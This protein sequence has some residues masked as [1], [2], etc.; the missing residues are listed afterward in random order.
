MSKSNSAGAPKKRHGTRYIRLDT[1]K[2]EACWDCIDEC[3]G[4]ALGKMNLW[5][6]KHVVFKDA[7]E[8]IGCLK[9]VKVC[10]NGVFEP[11]GKAAA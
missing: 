1:S 11:V 9:C 8:C 3:K 10:P 2:C 6:H 4:G 5:F 7:G